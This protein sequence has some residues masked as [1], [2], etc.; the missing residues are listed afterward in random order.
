MLSGVSAQRDVTAPDG[1]AH[2]C[3]LSTTI[4]R[5]APGT[6]ARR[7]VVTVTSAA[8]RRTVEKSR[9]AG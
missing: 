5:R 1:H 7:L 2:R 4:G 3:L 6:G 9:H 8:H